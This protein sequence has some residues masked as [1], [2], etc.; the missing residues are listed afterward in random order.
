MKI[1]FLKH[2]ANSHGGILYVMIS[3][4]MELPVLKILRVIGLELF[5]NPTLGAKLEMS[6]EFLLSVYF[7]LDKNKN[8]QTRKHKTPLIPLR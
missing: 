7:I 1:F 4:E 3:M 5:V 8:K 6:P 2:Y